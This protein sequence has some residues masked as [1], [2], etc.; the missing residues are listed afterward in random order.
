V[1]VH[2]AQQIGIHRDVLEIVQLDEELLNTVEASACA[3]IDALRG[4]GRISLAGNSGSAADAQYLAAGFVSR[5]DFDRPTVL[6]DTLTPNTSL[7][8][9]IGNDYGYEP[10][11]PRQIDAN[12]GAV[13]VFFG[14]STSGRSPNVVNALGQ[15]RARDVITAGFTGQD[16]GDMGPLCGLPGPGAG[17]RDAEVPGCSYS[18]W[19]HCVPLGRENSLHAGRLRCRG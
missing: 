11:F 3:C 4:G 15:G 14:N 6:G 8:T 18:S 13:D 7:P 19:A 10:P 1:R 12:A 9:A 17:D 16:G 5:V 2:I